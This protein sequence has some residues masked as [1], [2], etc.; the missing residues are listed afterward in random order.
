MAFCNSC[1]ASLTPG[2]R[3]CNKCGAAVLAST[4]ASNFATPA[5]T[6][7]VPATSGPPANTGQGSGA[8]K[9]ILIVVGV[10]VVLGMLSVA[11]VGFFAWRVAHHAHIHQNGNNVKVDTPF[12]SVETTQDPA[13]AARNIGVDL[14]PGA[15]VLRNGSASATFGGVHTASLHSE[16]TDSVDKVASFYKAKFPNAMVTS[17]DSGRCTIISNDQ[18]SMITI[19]I[20]AQGDKTKIMIT[21]V[22][23][24]SDKPDTSSN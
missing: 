23:R 21:N 3:F 6:S 17:S 11:S 9:V 14:Y 12:G 13:A 4:P 18:K 22:S 16:S 8:L 7:S 5:A 19:N 24:N 10:I 20:E 2:T 15:E 1:G